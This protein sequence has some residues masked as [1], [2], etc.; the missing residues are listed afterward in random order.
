[1]F[2]RRREESGVWKV[3]TLGLEIDQNGEKEKRR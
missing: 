2:W 1:M 3:G